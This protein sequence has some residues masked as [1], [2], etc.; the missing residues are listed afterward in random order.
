[1]LTTALKTR[2]PA[3]SVPDTT[4][5][6]VCVSPG[7]SSKTHSNVRIS[8][9]ALDSHSQMASSWSSISPPAQNG[10]KFELRILR[11]HPPLSH[12][13]ESVPPEPPLVDEV[14]VV[15]LPP[16]APPE[17]ALLAEVPPAEVPPAEVSLVGLLLPESSPAAPPCPV[18]T[19]LVVAV[20]V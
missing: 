13:F 11:P 19:A 20:D 8:C 5:S 17:S 18:R 2:G 12:A 1:M 15:P 10:P 4:P 7:G 6:G 3:G 14:S 9:A 16:A